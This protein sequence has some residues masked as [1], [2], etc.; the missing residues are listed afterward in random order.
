MARFSAWQKIADYDSWFSTA[1]GYT[2]PACYELGIGYRRDYVRVKYV[3]E[4]SNER[5]RMYEYATY[6]SHLRRYIEAELR[7]GANLYYRA[8][9]LKSKQA[10][11]T[12]QNNLLHRRAQ[13]GRPYEWN[14]HGNLRRW[15]DDPT[16]T[17]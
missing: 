11:I 8:Q 5:R 10:A 17:W 7:A 2:G 13:E 6:G 4:T 9:A 12:R 15:L 1:V 3:G 16:D 14:A